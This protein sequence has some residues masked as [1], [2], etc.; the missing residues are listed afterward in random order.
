MVRTKVGNAPVEI[1]HHDMAQKVMFDTGFS[2]ISLSYLVYNAAIESLLGTGTCMATAQA[3][4]YCICD[5]DKMRFYPNITFYTT[6]AVFDVTPR[7]YL[8]S[9]VEFDV[10]LR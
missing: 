9:P 1:S 3:E 4:Y 7:E 10:I 6:K 2:E 5:E 8:I